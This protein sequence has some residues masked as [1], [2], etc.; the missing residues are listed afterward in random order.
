[1]LWFWIAVGLLTSAATASIVVPLL[2]GGRRVASETQSDEARRLAV[3]RDRRGEIDADRDA[4]RL[5]AE[6][7]ARA[8]DELI[9]DAA[10][11][12]VAAPHPDPVAAHPATAA[13]AG[14]AEAR[15]PARNRV[16]A[17]AAA[18]GLAIA[19]PVSALL[20]YSSIGA[21]SLITLSPAEMRGELDERRVSE[22]LEELQERVARKPDDAE[23]WALLGQVN[24]MKGD[25]PASVAAYTRA[26]ELLPRDA[27]LLADYAEVV[28]MSQGGD[29]KG[30]PIELLGRALAADPNEGK[31]VALMG[32]AQYRLGNREAALRY[33]RQLAATLEPGSE[34]ARQIA[35]VV[36]RIESE[37][38]PAAP[39]AQAPAA[40]GS[41]AA[42]PGGAPTAAAPAGEPVV[43]GSIT[44]AEH[45]A[46]GVPAGAALFVIARAPDGPPIPLAAAK[47]APGG[48]PLSFALG[49]A[50]A[51]DRSRPLSAAG[52]IV[53]EARV[54]LAGEATRRSGDL[55]GRSAVV[56]PGAKGVAIRIDQS[57]P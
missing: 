41:A 55:F 20:V 15:P 2:G 35:E 4:A 24:A 22:I 54:S 32:A 19:L 21:P 12:L 11:Q 45:L 31:A 52:S 18:I 50:Q 48:W 30:R 37:L 29:F 43:S 47:L 57:V 7:A 40:G 51:M 26:A 44:I 28:V 14:S 49:D 3:Y 39:L 23:A 38:S 5:S 46:K 27:R 17:I 16:R 34:Q 10:E 1:M 33:M 36:T 25:L 8:L 9:E 42:G 6:E 56:A 13:Q 53:I